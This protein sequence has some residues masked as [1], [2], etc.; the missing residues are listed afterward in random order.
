MSRSK[1]ALRSAL[2]ASLIAA[3][4]TPI[5]GSEAA[6]AALPTGFQEQVVFSGLS[7]P[8][9]IE[10]APDG[11]IFVAEK[12]GKIKV[13]DNLADPTPD[14]FADLSVAVHNQ[15]DR[16]LLGLALAPN[17][18]TDP[19]VYV[20]YTYDAKLGQT[21]PV[22]NDVCADANG[23]ACVVSARLSRL[24]AAGN[25]M[26]G[27]EQPL[28]SDWC[29]QYPS[30]SIG[31]LKF[32]A[33]GALYVSGGDGASFNVVD[34]GQLGSPAN[35]CGDPANEGGAL[36]SQDVLTTADPTGLNGSILR[37]DPNTGAALPTNPLAASAD[38]NARRIV[39]HGLRNPFRMTVRPGTNEIW[40]GDV[41]WNTWEEI[42]RV[43]TPT[44]GPTNF[45]W[46]C[47][48][49]NARQSGY[50]S[51]DRPLCENLYAGAGQSAP[52][53]T[54]NHGAKVVA[55]ES[56]PSGGS[57]ISGLAFAPTTGGSYPAGYAGA[58]F[59]SDY[60]RNCIWAMMPGAGGLPDPANIITFDGGASGPADLQM[61]PGGELYYVSLGSNQ[62][63]RIRYYPNNQPPVAAFTATPTSGSSPLA[64]S[65]NAGTSSDADPADAGLLKYAWDF[66]NDGTTDSTAVT[67][68]FTYATA[69]TYTA[70]LTVT[71]TAGAT[72]SKTVT[73]TAGN[74]APT[75][76]IDTPAAT[77]TWA[78]GDTIAFSGHATDPQQGALPASALSW[79]V[80]LHHCITPDNCHEHPMNTFTGVA[81]G[82]ITAPDHE[83]PSYVE[84]KLT[85]TDSGGLTSTSSISVQPKTVNLA[86]TSSPAGL[87]LTVGSATKTTPFSLTVIQG[88]TNSVSAPTPQS[89]G[90]TS[91]SFT[92]WSDAGAQTHVIT[93]PATATT[94]TATYTGS[95]P[96]CGDAY[97]YTCSAGPR[98]FVPADQTVLTLKGDDA[99]QQVA[100]P[101]PMVFYGQTYSS[102][103]IDT[104]G[105]LSFTAPNGSSW[106][107]GAIPSAPAANKP[108]A[109]VY[110]FWSDL[111][112][113]ASASVRTQLS[114]SAPDRQFVVEWRNVRF[115]DN[116]NARV[117]FETVLSENGDVA[118]AW[119]DIDTLATEQGSASTVGIENAAGTVAL[120]YSLNQPTLRSGNGVLF[121]PPSGPPPPTG[122]TL[123]GKVSASGS[124]AALPGTRIALSP[125]TATAVTGADGTYRIDGL[126][127][128]T[129]AVTA[130]A[131][132]GQVAT[133]NAVLTG[134]GGATLN[135]GVPLQD[136]FGY[137][138][139]PGARSFIRA[140]QTVLSLTGDD[141]Y[142][143]VTL[144][145]PVKF[146][147]TTYTTAWVDTN[148]VVT[149][150]QPTGS[151]WNHSAIPSAAAS[152]KANA[153]IYPFWE[154]LNIDASASVR[155]AVTGSAPNRQF[156]I[157]WRNAQFFED[158]TARAS[159]E[160]VFS[161]NGDIAVAW[162][163]VDGTTFEQGSSATIG[164]ENASGT[165]ALQYSLN[166]PVI[167]NGT[168]VLFHPPA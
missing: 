64:V 152:N 49:G 110:P 68:N 22:Y 73:I 42:D 8:T 136:S 161:E 95:A 159:F 48:E 141:Y 72:N 120:Q 58:L 94:Y 10:F 166:Q 15:W 71:D 134:S 40:A 85:A 145:F 43:V 31:D 23:G 80:I 107:H 37:L 112:V 99:F 115:W 130:T 41:G 30:H 2:V 59:F 91:Y 96:A 67:A 87:Q 149:F 33:D 105:V 154:D 86:F 13:F 124:G 101:F 29:Q 114:G 116:A 92:S 167:R 158:T 132:G 111:D 4:I 147:G 63:R 133:G 1:S 127:A 135:L 79:Q 50:D 19:S 119:K 45:G 57:S 84:F 32:G 54:Y 151:A 163:D 35:P 155:T 38:A 103:W 143:Q 46:P 5:A 139:T 109:S 16:G 123:T 76:F 146:Y 34:Y 17:F 89:Q 157:E 82:S 53:Y 81:G 97:G 74:D 12:G 60:S 28:I 144:P 7:Q 25:Q 47:Y 36:R 138:A 56:C 128:G 27:T 24:T 98:T 140:D 9:N 70:K 93:A 156:V 3:V 14:V 6:T 117:S 125:G 165:V 118:V 26:T 55:G 77:A 129:Y 148:G 83:Y 153:A 90:S 150:V 100:L 164:I 106:N 66:T 39:A 126:A 65:F 104:N 21:A 61:G 108:N 121:H 160:V 62:I 137:T 52:Y 102:A 78:A 18:P 162:A 168:G 142:Q 51:A 69:G 88:S 20:L 122:G 44:T 11:R 75:A 113:D 131:P